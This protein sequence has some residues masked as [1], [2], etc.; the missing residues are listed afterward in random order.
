MSTFTIDYDKA[1][2]AVA[3]LAGNL[4]TEDEIRADLQ[5]F[6]ARFG[7]VI[8]DAMNAHL[9][10]RLKAADAAAVQAGTIHIDA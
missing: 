1:K 10:G 8:D 6:L 5:S 4:P 7:V 2:S 9:L 3:S